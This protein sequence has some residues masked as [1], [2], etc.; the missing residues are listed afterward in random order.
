MDIQDLGAEL[1]VNRCL[2][3]D[4][5]SLIYYQSILGNQ[6]ITENTI[7]EF[8]RLVDLASQIETP[9][10]SQQD[11]LLV[12]HLFSDTIDRPIEEQCAIC[13]G[14][15]QTQTPFL[16]IPGCLHKFHINCAT[17]W[18]RERFIC[19]SCRVNLKLNLA[20]TALQNIRD[21]LAQ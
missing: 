8:Q 14:D 1:E 4:R 3:Y 9:K 17:A 7:G 21:Q 2:E 6:Q 11:L 10:A 5:L 19:P 16:T 13:I 20:E 12:E 18:F 15:L